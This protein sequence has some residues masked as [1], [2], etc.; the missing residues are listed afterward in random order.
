MSLKVFNF[1]TNQWIPYSSDLKCYYFQATSKDGNVFA[2]TR[3]SSECIQITGNKV[4]AIEAVRIRWNSTSYDIASYTS[5]E[6]RRPGQKK[7]D[8]K[9]LIK[10]SGYDNDFRD[11]KRIQWENNNCSFR[12]RW[13]IAGTG[14]SWVSSTISPNGYVTMRD[15]E[16]EWAK[17]A[18]GTYGTSWPEIVTEMLAIKI[19]KNKG[20]TQPIEWPP[21]DE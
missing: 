17:S 12:V 13:D 4:L 7:E 1:S 20:V 9:H 10:R 16:N 3:L 15:T 18:I 5:E 6:F 14:D 21:K 8:D 11:F 2:P 19:D